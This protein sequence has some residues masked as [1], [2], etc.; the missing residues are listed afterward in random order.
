MDNTTST[1]E[2]QENNYGKIARSTL[3]MTL[4]TLLSRVT[5]L[6][7][8]WSMAYALG[9]TMLASSYQ[10]ANNLPNI[11]YEIFAGGMIAAA[12]LPVLMEVKEKQG[13]DG[14]NKY[15]SNILNIVFLILMAISLLSIVFAEPIVATQTFTMNGDSEV[16]QTAV[17][18]FRIFAIQ[19]LFYGLGGITQGMLNAER[20]FFLTSIAPAINNIVVIISF[21][22]YAFLYASQPQ[23]ALII[24]AVGTTLG[25]IAQFIVMLPQIRSCGFK[26]SFHISLTDPYLKETM[27]LAIPTIVYVITTIVMSSCKNAFSLVPSDS[28][29]AMIAYAWLWFQLPYGILCV[30]L[31]RTMFTE[32]SDAA[33]RGNYKQLREY[34]MKGLSVTLLIIIP[35]SAMLAALAVPLVGVFRAG[36]FSPEDVAAV[37]RLL[38]LWSASLPLY[39]V[40]MYLYNAFASL[41]RFGT[42]A[43]INIVLT[44]GVVAMYWAFTASP[45]GLDGIPIADGIYFVLYAVVAFIALNKLVDGKLRLAPLVPSILKMLAVSLI[46]AGIVYAIYCTILPYPSGIA[47]AMIDIAIGGVIGIAI[48][49]LGS[50]LLK[51]DAITSVFNKVIGKLRR[52]S[53]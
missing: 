11:I 24:L 30:S 26:W 23:L 33:A 50:Y 25:V 35:L 48:I 29:P 46:A 4:G 53:K 43:A 40:M 17:W 38:V 6:L 42:Y 2:A 10:I 15:S 34:I 27:R 7:R 31:S 20:R 51:I 13:R 1:A 37:A 18:L 28:G 36:A 8:T 16:V 9:A 5:G 49:L 39:A 12:F 41:K 47:T 19:V 14:A 22:A 52:A 44:L 3:L 45:L 32:M 21:V